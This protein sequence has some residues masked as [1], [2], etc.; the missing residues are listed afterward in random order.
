MSAARVVVWAGD[1]DAPEILEGSHPV[2][3]VLPVIRLVSGA[4]E[5]L[6]GNRRVLEQ[7]RRA[8]R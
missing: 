8:T 2:L 6:L 3:V 4:G 1:N 7:K 5:N